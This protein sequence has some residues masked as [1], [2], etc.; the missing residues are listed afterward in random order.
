[1][2]VWPC[3]HC[4]RSEACT[5]SDGPSPT[6]SSRAIEKRMGFLRSASWPA[7]RWGWARGTDVSGCLH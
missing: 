6:L 4:S 5:A 3:S 2:S 7:G 1:M